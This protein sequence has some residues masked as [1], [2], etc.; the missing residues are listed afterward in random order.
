VLRR[1][2][3]GDGSPE[4]CAGLDDIDA[5]IA[6]RAIAVRDGKITIPASLWH[7]IAASM[8]LG[9]MVSAALGNPDEL[10]WARQALRDMKA[11]PKGGPL[12]EVLGQIIDGNRDRGIVRQLTGIEGLGSLLVWSLGLCA[13]TVAPRQRP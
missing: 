12:G 5:A 3:D 13:A 11:S 8:W 1:I 10:A 7:A 4:L 6:A 9:H 2:R